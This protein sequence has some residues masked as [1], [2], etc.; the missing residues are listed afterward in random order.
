MDAAVTGREERMDPT[1]YNLWTGRKL[2]EFRSDKRAPKEVSKYRCRPAL[3]EGWT[4]GE[5]MD[6]AYCCLYFAR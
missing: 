6:C 4:R 5:G 1:Q 3:D 2:R